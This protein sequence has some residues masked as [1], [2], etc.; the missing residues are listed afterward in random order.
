MHTEASRKLSSRA[1]MDVMELTIGFPTELVE[2]LSKIP[3]MQG[4]TPEEIVSEVLTEAVE[5]IGDRL[6][7][8]DVLKKIESGEERTYSSTEL[9]NEFGLAD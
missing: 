3:K 2:R 6:I 4:K 5:D 1:S 8:E 7:G 9:C